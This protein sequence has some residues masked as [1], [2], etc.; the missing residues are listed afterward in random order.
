MALEESEEEDAD[1]ESA[2]PL[3]PE[4]PSELA[5]LGFGDELELLRESVR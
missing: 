3:E 4:V 1:P 5:E 2:D